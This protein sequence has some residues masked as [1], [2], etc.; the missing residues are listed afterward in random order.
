M[1]VGLDLLKM[2]RLYYILPFALVLLLL[3]SCSEREYLLQSARG[4][5]DVMSRA[6]PIQDVLAQDDVT[7]D[8]REQ[9]LKVVSLR[10]FAVESLNLPDSGSY[11]EYADLERPYAVWNLVVA[12]ELSLELNRWCFPIAGCVTYRGYFDESTASAFSEEF[13]AQGFDVDVYGV[14]AYSTLN[15]FDD[16][17]LNT[18]LVNDDLRLASLLFHEMAHQIVYVKNDTAFNESYAKTVELEGLRRW[19]Q[20]SGSDDLWQQCLTR[21]S[22]SKSFHGFLAG[23]RA[24]LKQVYDSTL[25]DDQKRSAKQK[26][27]QEAYVQYEHL[28]TG[29]GGYD[30]YDS[31]MKRGLNNAR[32]SSMATY[33][34]LVPAFQ[35]LLRHVGSDLDKFYIEVKDL[36]TLPGDERLAKLKSYSSGLQAALH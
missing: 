35:A 20:F 5:W 2:R 31:W 12:P 15:W 19:L 22:H 29:W 30:G 11:K 1:K 7:E 25:N 36:S 21:E 23:V 13:S 28:K 26:V 3:S 27:F 16:P 24:E 34:D 9:L 6:R 14:Q 33:H 10:K 8:L 17:V 18:F 32:L 4:Q